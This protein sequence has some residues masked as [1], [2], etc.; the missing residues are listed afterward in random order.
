MDVTSFIDKKL[1][2]M[3]CFK[4]QLK[5]APHSRSLDTIKALASYRGNTIGVNF[6]ESFEVERIIIK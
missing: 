3:S 6:A 4:S 5:S 1:E 2:A